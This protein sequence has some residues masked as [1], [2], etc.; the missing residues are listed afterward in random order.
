MRNPRIPL[1]IAGSLGFAAV[2]LM[3]LLFAMACAT[4]FE[5]ARGTEQALLVFYKSWWFEGLLGLLALN[6]LAAVA[7]RFPFTKGHTGFLLTHLGVVLTL[8]GAVVTKHWGIDG[9]VGIPEGSTV[10]EFQIGKPRLTVGG[11]GDES[12]AALDLSDGPFRSLEP[13]D[14]GGDPSARSGDLEVSAL[15]YLP[16]AVFGE[17][18]VEDESG[19]GRPAV[20]VS[21]I[22]SGP[23]HPEHTDWLFA[24]DSARIGPS[25]VS[26]KTIEKQEELDELLTPAP[27]A[28]ESAGSRGIVRVQVGEES[29]DLP[30]E[31]C[32]ERSVPVGETEYG[33]RVL[34]YL[35]HATVGANGLTNASNEPVNPAIECTLT[36]PDGPERRLAFALH[37]EFGA[38]HGN[39][40]GKTVRVSFVAPEGGLEKE[41]TEIL[42][43]PDG[44]LHVRFSRGERTISA[45]RITPGET[46]DTPQSGL[47]LGLRQ[48]LSSARRK[49]TADPVQP[50]RKTRQPA[51]LVR[52]ARGEA[53]REA[54]VPRYSTR[55]VTL[56]GREYELAY[57]DTSLP[58]GFDLT[59]DRFHIGKYPG[60]RQPRSFESHI[61]ITDPV[62]GTT[63][64]RVISMNNPT[65]FEGYTLFQSS[66]RQEQGMSMSILSV[67]RDP[68]QPIV[69][70]GYIATLLGMA[71]VLG[72]RMSDQRKK[73]AP[74]MPVQPL[75]RL[76]ASPGGV[77]G[78]GPEGRAG[79]KARET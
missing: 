14:L 51:V 38:M 18:V 40:E 73:T 32:L 70:A 34:R 47:R 57:G 19:E 26:L 29:F 8:A 15:R 75:G 28:G 13:V 68:G 27:D 50:C 12:S 64:S 49:L 36:G 24:G 71:I 66:Y 16:D 69:F 58:L 21:V 5:S 55:T 4:V 1:R 37:P 67:S 74:V 77:P 65:S 43:G 52:I 31:D 62:T 60:E 25:T 48:Q 78:D 39:G 11:S 6:L 20:E 17:A 72:L 2:L 76:S 45:T 44:A 46:V 79:D 30:L 22:H 35:P 56:G 61:T 3:I 41:S 54:W 9:Q 33:I 53:A 59:L 42:L 10:Q 7:L 23:D 63:Q